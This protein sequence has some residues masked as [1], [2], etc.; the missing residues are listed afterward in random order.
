MIGRYNTIRMRRACAAKTG[1]KAMKKLRIIALVLFLC[2]IANAP[3]LAEFI[4]P[5]AT[6]LPDVQTEAA[7][8][9]DVTAVEDLPWNLVLVNADHA[10][11]ENW[12]CDLMELS[13]GRKID[14][15]M[16]ES[17][18]A[19]FD[20]CRADGLLPMVNSGYR[21]YEDQKA[22]L[23]KRYN[24][25]RD[26]GMSVEDAQK[27]TLKW[28]AYPGHSEHHTGLAVDIDSSNTEKCSNDRVW[29]WM[30]EHCAEYGF[31]WRY[32]GEKT[33]ITGISNEDWHFRYVGVEA[34]TYIMQNQLCLEE[35]LEQK[36][37]IK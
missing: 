30:Y 35:Y 17:L 24:R 10:L 26:Q 36:Y 21:S 23:M 8:R 16:Y 25:Y 14:R 19:M 32:P 29:Q 15:R 28:V 27:E 2:L 6:P 22:I 31:I 37:G 5:Q 3:A 18:Q 7:A 11:P 34:A 20:A 13:N 4:V 12:Q 9:D 1:E 33:A